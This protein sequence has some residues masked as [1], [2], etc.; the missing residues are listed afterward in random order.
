LPPRQSPP[1]TRERLVAE[2]LKLI[3]EHGFDALSMRRLAAALGVDPMAAYY[4][5]PGGKPALVRLLV[6]H[7]FSTLESPDP[8]G[9][10]QER[11]E[12]WANAYRAVALAHP[13][14]VLQVVSDVEAVGAA[15]VRANEELYAALEAGGLSPDAIVQGA[16]V[17]VDF[18]NGFSLGAAAASVPEGKDTVG[19]EFTQ[20]NSPY[21]VQRRVLALASR[22]ETDAYFTF[23]IRTIIAGLSADAG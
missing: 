15:A 2:A 10:W 8:R 23:G 3:D 5:V 17:L 1:L 21:P 19:Q 11:V 7:V 9:D 16:G 22:H 13:N 12:R 4:H 20:T 18:I 14:L 6:E